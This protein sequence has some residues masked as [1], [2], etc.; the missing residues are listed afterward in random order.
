MQRDSLHGAVHMLGHIRV[1]LSAHRYDDGVS[2]V[3]EGHM[4]SNSLLFGALRRHHHYEH[5]S[6][7]QIH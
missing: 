1:V 4:V 2:Y 6:H 3:R 7:K 5:L